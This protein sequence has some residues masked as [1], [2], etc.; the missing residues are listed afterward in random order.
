MSI[1]F[2]YFSVNLIWK[3]LT[4]HDKKTKKNDGAEK[5]SENINAKYH[6]LL[7]KLQWNFVLTYLIFL[8]VEYFVEVLMLVGCLL[9]SMWILI[10]HRNSKRIGDCCCRTGC[11]C[12][13]ISVNQSH[14]SVELNLLWN[15]LIQSFFFFWKVLLVC[16][17]RV[18]SVFKYNVIGVL[19]CNVSLSLLAIQC[20]F[21]MCIKMLSRFWFLCCIFIYNI[22]IFQC[23]SRGKQFM[24]LSLFFVT[25][26]NYKHIP[27][28]MLSHSWIVRLLCD[29]IVCYTW[30]GVSVYINICV[31]V[32][33]LV[34][35]FNALAIRS[36]NRFFP[37][38]KIHIECLS[39]NSVYAKH[40][41]IYSF[42]L[43]MKT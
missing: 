33:L 26:V 25:P 18:Y 21:K 5:K 31:C 23:W 14:V 10:Y 27:R 15:L 42:Q 13:L 37:M 17:C 34:L 2:V 38:P 24:V 40:I 20:I 41:L 39:H 16:V 11:R 4:L 9:R 12:Q 7:I 43:S 35:Q 3:T 6:I 8:C 29:C 28:Q 22:H 36:D 1:E 32:L 30:N 19:V